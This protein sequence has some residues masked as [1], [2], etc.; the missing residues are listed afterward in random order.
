MARLHNEAM[1]VLIRRVVTGGYEPGDFLPREIDMAAEFG[2]SRGVARE[3]IRALEERRL[4]QVIHGRGARVRP[5]RE[6]NVLDV[7]VMSA[8]VKADGARDMLAQYMECRLVLEVESAGMAAERAG[9]TERADLQAALERMVAVVEEHD[10]SEE[11]ERAYTD[12]DVAFHRSVAD[13]TGNIP[14]ARALEPLHVAMRAAMPAFA[15]P[16]LRTERSIPEHRRIM[17]AVCAGDADGAREAMR[18]HLHTAYRNLLET[19][20]LV[21]SVSQSGRD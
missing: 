13:A 1:Q 15:R 12:A 8:I 11:A 9:P 3:C 2:V 19:D 20:E 5:A 6:W 18:A 14:L 17:E 4:V 7:D 16:R 10:L 21:K